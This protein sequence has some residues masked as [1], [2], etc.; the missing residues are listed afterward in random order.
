MTVRVSSSALVRS[1]AQSLRE[2]I[3]S[4]RSIG[5]LV[6]PGLISAIA[7]FVPR[8]FAVTPWPR[9]AFVACC[10]RRRHPPPANRIEAT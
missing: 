10:G 6:R 9:A 2:E 3:S 8:F 7:I 5:L 1:A 4:T